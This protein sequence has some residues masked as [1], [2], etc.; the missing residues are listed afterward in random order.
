MKAEEHL[1]LFASPYSDDIAA[2]G[3]TVDIHFITHIS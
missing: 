1:A 2:R 3:P